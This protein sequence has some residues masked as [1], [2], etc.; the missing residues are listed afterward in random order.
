MESG[1]ISEAKIYGDFFGKAEISE[2]EQMLS[3]LKHNR[4]DVEKLIS[5]VD[6]KKYFGKIENKN[7][8]NCMF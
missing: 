1:I 3:G 5:N 8:I 2:F 6:V 4:D 7:I